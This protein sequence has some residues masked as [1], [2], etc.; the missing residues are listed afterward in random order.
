MSIW[1]CGLSYKLITEGSFVQKIHESS[2]VLLAI[3]IILSI[4]FGSVFCGFICPFGSVQEWIGK[5]GKIIFK[6]RFNKFIPSKYD[7]YFRYFRY[8]VL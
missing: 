8:I 7:R 6:K 2:F 4:L 5:L 1:R 3:V